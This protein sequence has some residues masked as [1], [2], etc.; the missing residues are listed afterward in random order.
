[1]TKL[2]QIEKS[3]AEL[4]GEELEAF[5][6]WFEAFQEARWDQQIEADSATG[7]LDQLAD[8]ALADFR[9]GRTRRL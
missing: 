7:K 9:A 6:E 8:E 5:S 2:E 3:V 4:S 1:M